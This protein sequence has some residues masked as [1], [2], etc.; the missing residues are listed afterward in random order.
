MILWHHIS[1]LKYTNIIPAQLFRYMKPE[2]ITIII[3]GFTDLQLYRPFHF[4]I[5]SKQEMFVIH[6]CPPSL[7]V[8]VTLTFDLETQYSIG[9][10]Y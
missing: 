2:T 9:V 10:L 4:N 6:V 3:S 8:T 5:D 1:Y 7:N